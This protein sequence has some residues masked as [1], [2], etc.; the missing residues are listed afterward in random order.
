MNGL[1]LAYNV[2]PFFLVGT[3]SIPS[4]C[5][6]LSLFFSLYTECLSHETLITLFPSQTDPILLFCV[7]EFH[8]FL[9][10]E[11]K[12]KNTNEPQLLTRNHVSNCII[13]KK[14]ISVLSHKKPFF[15]EQTDN[16]GGNSKNR[17]A[18]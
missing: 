10:L 3:F 7:L 14:K 13:K 5:L 11:N 4:M 12:N 2:L 9:A 8:L 18:P 17:I 16:D 1:L 15:D 6:P